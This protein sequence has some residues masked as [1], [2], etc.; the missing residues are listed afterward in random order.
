MFIRIFG[1]NFGHFSL[2]IPWPL[3][4]RGQVQVA[5]G[6][7]DLEGLP[8]EFLRL[9][10]PLKKGRVG[11]ETNHSDIYRGYPQSLKNDLIPAR[12]PKQGAN[13]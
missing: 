13:N 4:L 7:T 11:I 6:T 3:H 2:Q 9:G 12:D 1:L 5:R 8:Q 10:Q